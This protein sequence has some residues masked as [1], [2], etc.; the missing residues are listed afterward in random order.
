M[1]PV[2]RAGWLAYVNPNRPLTPRCGVVI[3]MRLDQPDAV[4]LCY[5]KEYLRRTATKLVVSQ[6]SPLEDLEFQLDRIIAAH[7]IVGLAEM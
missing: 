2:L 3:Q 4:P 6:Y 1:F 7:R 5:I